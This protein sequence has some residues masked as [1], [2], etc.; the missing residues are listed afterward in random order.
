MSLLLNCSVCQNQLIDPV[1]LSCGFTVCLTCLPS[2]EEFQK[3]T[4]VCPVQQCNKESHLFGPSLYLDSCIN[5]IS[6]LKQPDD[7]QVTESLQCSIGNHLLEHPITSHCGHSFCKLC[8][9][10][11]KIT[12]D[13]CKKCQKRLPSYQFIQHQP[14]NFILQ[15][16]LSAYNQQHAAQPDNVSAANHISNMSISFNPLSPSTFYQA[17]PIFLTDFPVLPSQ[18]LRIPIYTEQHRTFFINSLLIC[19]E[20]QSLC[21]AI[22]AKSKANHKSHYG[23]MVKVNAVEQRSNDMVVD[24]IGLDRF[25]VTSV[26][27]E[28]DDFLQADL[29]M[30]FE[31]VQDLVSATSGHW[32]DR[33]QETLEKQSTKLNPP[34]SPDSPMEDVAVSSVILPKSPPA[35]PLIFTPATKLSSRI[36]DFVSDLSHSAP[37]TSFCTAIEGLLG[38]VWLE[39][40]QGLHGSLPAVDNAV[41][42]C[43]WAA[44]VFPVSN[45]DRY[46]LLETDALEDRLKIVLSW[47]DDLK[48]QWGSCRKTAMNSAAKV[49]K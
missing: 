13:S 14:P 39:S 43:W 29:E 46:H 19:K 2:Q 44:V 35:E 22:M 9:L 8:V 34:P 18:K 24:V 37:S 25:R 16:V 17:I 7:K 5:Q 12:N 26:L 23:T 27:K 45:T 28:T 20:Y 10:Q 42:M 3:S 48:S 31:N 4:F 11:Y 32:I 40:V 33:R 1:T 21:F 30:K 49:G 38:P 15:Q 41:A 36:H 47:I 6:K